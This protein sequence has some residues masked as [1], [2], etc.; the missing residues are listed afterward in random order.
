MPAYLLAALGLALVAGATTVAADTVH[1]ENGDRITGTVVKKDGEVLRLQT[2]YAGELKIRWADV[3][4]I[5]TDA[6]TPALLE[7]GTTRAATRFGGAA[8]PIPLDRVTYLNPTPGELGTGF[9]YSGRLTLAASSTSGNTDTERFYGEGQ[10]RGRSKARRFS[11]GANGTYA[12]DSGARTADNWLANGEHDWFLRRWDFL[13]VRGSIEH[14]P[15]RDIERRYTAGGGYGYQVFDTPDLSVSLRG[16]LDYV[17]TDW[18]T[19]PEEES[20]ALGWGI[21]YAQWLWLRRLQVFFDQDGSRNVGDSDD[22]VIR[23]RTGLR[24]SVA[25]GLDL[26]AQLNLDWESDPA[27]GRSREWCDERDV[28]R[29]ELRRDGERIV[30]KIVAVVPLHEVAGA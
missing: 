26:N 21:R 3:V 30:A 7:D 15:F 12:S 19:E 28:R 13:Y 27:P 25:N 6:P 1:L 14:D 9:D 18:T 16:G 8:A 20:P 22:L 29:L 17:A 4:E 10:F 23:T 2:E 5:V 11:L 24:L